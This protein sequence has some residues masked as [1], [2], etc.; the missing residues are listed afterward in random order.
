M[1]KYWLHVH[2]V[3]DHAL[4]QKKV[5]QKMAMYGTISLTYQTINEPLPLYIQL[6]LFL[7]FSFE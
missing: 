6:L 7:A 4:D 1:I 3:L 2:Q 5:Q